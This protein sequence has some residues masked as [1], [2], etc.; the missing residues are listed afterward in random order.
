MELSDKAAF[1]RGEA[2]AYIGVSE[3]TLV[4]L[5]QEG[6]VTFQ[7][8]G[9]RVIVSKGELDKFLQKKSAANLESD[10]KAAIKLLHDN[11]YSVTK[12]SPSM[13]KD[14]DDCEKSDGMKD[15]I[16]CSCSVCIMQS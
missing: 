7:K 12:L 4:K 11:N 8:V 6:K 13:L 3:N 1:N 14:S 15:C 9:R 5:F 10:I 2:A 16:G